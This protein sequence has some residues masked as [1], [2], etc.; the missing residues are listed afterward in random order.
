[1]N[2]RPGLADPTRSSP[3]YSSCS[4]LSAKC[5]SQSVREDPDKGAQPMPLHVVFKDGVGKAD[6][7]SAN[8]G[9]KTQLNQQ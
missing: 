9:A 5:K 3:D 8:A 2:I 6:R 4:S 1:M 7:S